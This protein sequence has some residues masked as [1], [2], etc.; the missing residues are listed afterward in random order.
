MS[1]NSCVAEYERCMLKDK[2]QSKN[3]MR[4]FFQVLYKISYIYDAV[5]CRMAYICNVFKV[6]I[7][8]INHNLFSL[9]SH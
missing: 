1:L 7:T 9:V 8:M 4:I 6:I 5:L 3:D 2:R